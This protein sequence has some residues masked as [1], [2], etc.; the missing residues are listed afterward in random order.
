MKLPSR[1]RTLSA[2]LALG[3]PLARDARIDYRDIP[4]DGDADGPA[5]VP[6]RLTLTI[7]GVL[8]A[9]VDTY[10]AVLTG[11]LPYAAHAGAVAESAQTAQL[12]R[13]AEASDAEVTRIREE[14]AAAKQEAAELSA[15]V[16]R[17][18]YELGLD[19]ETITGLTEDLRATRM[20]VEARGAECLRLTAEVQAMKDAPSAGPAADVSQVERDRDA[21]KAQAEH[22]ATEAERAAEARVSRESELGAKLEALAAKLTAAQSAL[23]LKSA[24]TINAEN[25]LA[26]ERAESNANLQR[27]ADDT[28]AAAMRA[29]AAQREASA[30]AAR[31]QALEAEAAVRE[32]STAHRPAAVAVELEAAAA[33]VASLTSAMQDAGV[34]AEAAVQAANEEVTE[35]RTVLSEIRVALGNPTDPDQLLGDVVRRAINGEAVAPLLTLTPDAPPAAHVDVTPVAIDRVTTGAALPPEADPFTAAESAPAPASHLVGVPPGGPDLGEPLVAATPT[36]RTPRT[37]KPSAAPVAPV[38]AAAAASPAPAPAAP[39]VPV[40]APAAGVPDPLVVE[41]E[42]AKFLKDVVKMLLDHDRTWGLPE[43]LAWAR[44]HR[45]EV[46][47]LRRIPEHL[48]EDRVK[49]TAGFYLPAAPGA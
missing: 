30:L 31:V 49:T 16:D 4:P 11:E 26:N 1:L 33:Q 12:R 44:A 38:T 46:A 14:L 42:G 45:D 13:A 7:E 20:T 8:P 21:Y 35:L 15:K 34:R 39:T 28:L 2:V 10:L 6:T 29:E 37:P 17:A 24:E 23:G 22:A 19:S 5:P 25:A 9:E 18:V 47:I 40:E 48:V 3:A 43:L 41:A 27:A 32:T 36:P